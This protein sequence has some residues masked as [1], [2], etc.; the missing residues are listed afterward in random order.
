M[1]CTP[2]AIASEHGE[3]KT[4]SRLLPEAGDSRSAKGKQAYLEQVVVGERLFDLGSGGVHESAIGGL[5]GDAAQSFPHLQHV[6]V[7]LQ[8]YCLPLLSWHQHLCPSKPS[9]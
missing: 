6:V 5:A 8:H 1:S 3:S 2:A 7:P 9:I 4:D